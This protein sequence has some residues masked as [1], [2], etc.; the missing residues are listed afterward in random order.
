M[1]VHPTVLS[2]EIDARRIE[3][4]RQTLRLHRWSER[5]ARFSGRDGRSLP[6][7]PQGESL[8]SDAA[9][10]PFAGGTGCARA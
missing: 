1:I 2:Y 8:V 9:C 5:L 4:V 3:P 7:Q 6:L 10:G